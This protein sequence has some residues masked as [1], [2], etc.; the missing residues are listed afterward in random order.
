MKS[1]IKVVGLRDRPQQVKI[2]EQLKDAI[3]DV[4]KTLGRNPEGYEV[5][6]TVFIQKKVTSP[7]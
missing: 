7:K 1:S 6:C 5:V 4:L 3:R 2:G